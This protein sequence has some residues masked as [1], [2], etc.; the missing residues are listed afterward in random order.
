MKNVSFKL[1]D[2]LNARL[3]QASKQR[4]AAKSDIVRDALEA[5]FSGQQNGARLSCLDLAR[6]LA[7]SIDGPADLATNPKYMGGYGR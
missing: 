1:P 5:Y 3:E 2:E 4:G 6:D 7:G